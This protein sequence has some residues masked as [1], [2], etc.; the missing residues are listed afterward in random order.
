MKTIKITDSLGNK[1]ILEYNRRAVEILEK[2]GFS[3]EK[4]HEMP[5][6]MLPALFAG[7]FIM[8]NKKMSQETIDSLFASLPDKVKLSSTLVGMYNETVSVLLDD[9]EDTEGNAT[10]EIIE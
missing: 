8:H 4:I 10:W 6:T 2:S 3:I 7:A 5:A 1:Y 9:P